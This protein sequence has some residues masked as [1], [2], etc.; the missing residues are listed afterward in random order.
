MLPI[1][2]DWS[3]VYLEVVKADDKGHY[4]RSFFSGAYTIPQPIYIP[5]VGEQ[6]V[7][8]ELLV[9][10]LVE[11]VA[12]F[13]SIEEFDFKSFLERVGDARVVL[14]GEASHGTSEFY[15]MRQEL[16]KALIKERGFNIVAAEADWPDMEIVNK[17]VQGGSGPLMRLPFQRFPHW[18]W[19]NQEFVEF[20]E[21][22][23]GFNS[24]AQRPFYIYGLDLYGLGNA[25]NRV[26]E[27]FEEKDRSLANMIREHYS[28]L[29]PYMAD[30]SEYG[31]MVVTNR[32]Q[33]CEK[34]VMQ[35]LLRMLKERRQLNHSEAYF[36]AFQN[37]RVVVD[38]ERY[39]KVMYYGGADSW[40]LRDLHMFYTLRALLN[41]H[42]TG[43]KAVVW[44]HNSHIGNA[45][46]T[47][48]Y[49][50]GEINIGHLC[51]EAYG[52]QSYHVGFGTN[53]GTVAAAEHWGGPMKIMDVNPS[54]LESYERLFHRTGF[55]NFSLPLRKNESNARLINALSKPRIERA[56]GVIYRPHTE[57]QSHYFLAS[58]PGQFDEYIWMDRT[59]AVNALP[60][61][62]RS[63]SA[64]VFHPFA[65]IDA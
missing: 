14:I 63:L 38:A 18:M 59:T 6:A 4:K 25:M 24:R 20:A 32:L 41:Y 45:L 39:Y 28:C 12:W 26:V 46:A 34:E 48:M 15:R 56:I 29:S 1:G 57:R 51:R 61:L 47:Q 36:Y 43:S 13:D 49:S 8:E 16:T 52:H 27:F 54:F 53:T 65:V 55:A 44:A 11:N 37:A 62:G 7:P 30:P 17:Y 3:H 19:R 58:L 50:R 35:V 31:K 23:R 21:W 33:S 42:G 64:R 2:P 5:E 22:G 60:E 9:P 40:N 10:E